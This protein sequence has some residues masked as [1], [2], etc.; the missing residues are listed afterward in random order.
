[1]TSVSSLHLVRRSQP[2][3]LP[4][5]CSVVKAITP[6]AA[7]RRPL[8]V[9]ISQTET[10]GHEKLRASEGWPAGSVRAV[11]CHCGARR[12]LSTAQRWFTLETRLGGNRGRV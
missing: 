11:I 10:A 5:C 12:L 7:T 3:A 2:T 6:G 1:M 8:L 9:D 4:R